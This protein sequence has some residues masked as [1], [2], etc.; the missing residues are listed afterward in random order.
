MRQQ[1]TNKNSWFQ[2]ELKCLA[3]QFLLEQGRYLITVSINISIYFN[4]K[5]QLLGFMN[6]TST[7][8]ESK[9]KNYKIVYKKLS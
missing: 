9:K 7:C 1:N 5:Y 4:V 2:W 8:I 6:I 3:P